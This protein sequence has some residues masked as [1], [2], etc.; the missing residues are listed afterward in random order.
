MRIIILHV[1]VWC[2]LQKL[3][4]ILLCRLRQNELAVRRLCNCCDLLCSCS[5]VD[6]LSV[7]LDKY[8]EVFLNATQQVTI[9]KY[10]NRKL[11]PVS[12]CILHQYWGRALHN[13]R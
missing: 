6:V 12:T 11:L 13:V 5:T 7:T 4:H 2:V 1:H 9:Y 10:K 8:K 3:Y